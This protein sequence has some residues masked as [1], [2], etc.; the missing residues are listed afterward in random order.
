MELN[1][2][3]CRELKKI[4]AGGT[5]LSPELIYELAGAGDTDCAFIV[6]DVGR[7]LGVACA[8]L[9]NLLAPHEIIVCG[10]IAI[11]GEIVL[12]AMREE[13]N[14]SALPRSR[15]QVK[16]RLAPE[17]AKMPLLGAAALVAQELFDLPK[18]YHASP[19]ENFAFE[20]M[21]PALDNM[22]GRNQLRQLG[23]KRTIRASISPDL[24]RTR[25]EYHA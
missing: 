15:E 2:G 25:G 3:R 16:V 20:Q 21:N 6:R 12:N 17:R 8:N 18:L 19:E 5:N 4:L 7:Y 13:I 14:R 24:S 1:S 23:M 11:S 10:S 22:P 9:I